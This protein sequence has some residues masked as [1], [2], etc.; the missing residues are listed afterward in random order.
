MM[1]SASLLPTSA[2]TTKSSA[3]RS[4]SSSLTAASSVDRAVGDLDVTQSQLAQPRD[5]AVHPPLANRH[6][7]E[8][9][10]E[11]HRDVARAVE[12]ELRLQVGGH[13]RR[14]PPEV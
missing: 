11:H 10:A 7:G 5:E 6:L 3:R 9:A 8:R 2:R 14:A 13:E 4:I 12:L 1:K